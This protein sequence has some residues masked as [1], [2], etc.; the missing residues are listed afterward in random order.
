MS[1]QKSFV[2]QYVE[3][4]RGVLFMGQPI[5]DLT[6]E[7][8]IAMAVSGWHAEKAVRE[9]CARQLSFI[10]DLRRYLPT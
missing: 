5:E 6:R 4:S 2:D 9:E 7:E 3:L 1:L 8:L 10:T